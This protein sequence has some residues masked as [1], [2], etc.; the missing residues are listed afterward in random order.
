MVPILVSAQGQRKTSAIAAIAPHR[1][2]FTD[3]NL[4][5]RD[6]NASRKMRGKLVI[7]LDE[8]RGLKGRA[9]EDVKSFITRREEEWTP[10][11]VE[12]TRKFKR[13]FLL[14]GSTNEDN[15]LGDPTGERRYLPIEVGV[16]AKIDVEAIVRDREQLWAEAVHLYQKHGVMWQ[17]AEWLA[18]GEHGKFKGEVKWIA[19]IRDWLLLRGALSSPDLAPSDMPY[20]WGTEEVLVGAIGIP[21]AQAKDVDLMATGK[22]LKALG[23]LKKK[24]RRG[25]K[26][27]VPPGVKQELKE[28][29]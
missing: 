23:C 4:M 17:D 27:R 2:M 5:E 3:I 19:P 10:K 21:A 26:Y 8:L 6:D 1:D 9:V 29:Q 18:G 28:E 11:Y 15:F 25:W 20:E 22:A 13:R 16:D 12:F 7:E 24:T 14:W